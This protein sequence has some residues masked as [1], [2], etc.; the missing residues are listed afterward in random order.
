[1]GG[2][3]VV[4]IAVAPCHGPLAHHDATRIAEVDRPIFE[5]VFEAGDLRIAAC[6]VGTAGGGGRRP[7]LGRHF[8]G[9]GMPCTNGENEGR[10]SR[11]SAPAVGRAAQ[12]RPNSSHGRPTQ[13]MAC[14]INRKRAAA[15]VRAPNF[16]HVFVRS[17]LSYLKLGKRKRMQ[18]SPFSFHPKFSDGL[19][20]LGTP[21]LKVAYVLACDF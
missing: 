14:T 17:P 9:R 7:L 3:Y 15:R 21:P 19:G 5:H 10:E 4:W 18:S 8:P 12:P 11:D 13:P 1:M 20:G 2:M 6:D 16:A